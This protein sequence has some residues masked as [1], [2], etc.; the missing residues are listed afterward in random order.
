VSTPVGSEAEPLWALG[1][2]C[3]ISFATRPLH[4][5][6]TPAG[7]LKVFEFISQW[8]RFLTIS[9]SS[10]FQR[11]SVFQDVKPLRK[12]LKETGS[13]SSPV[14]NLTGEVPKDLPPRG[15]LSA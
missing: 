6:I 3:F 14:T 9:L 11:K 10:D 13:T 4:L 12:V 15:G 1:R 7:P 5:L 2:V 8:G